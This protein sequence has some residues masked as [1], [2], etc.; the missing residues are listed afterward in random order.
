MTPDV[1]AAEDLYFNSLEA[2]EPR[3]LL[4]SSGLFSIAQTSHT[5]ALAQAAILERFYGEPLDDHDAHQAPVNALLNAPSDPLQDYFDEHLHEHDDEGAHLDDPQKKAEHDAVFDLVAYED[6]THVALRSGL[7]SSPNTWLDLDGD[8]VGDP[9]VHGANV[10]IDHETTVVYDVVSNVELH[11]VRVDG[12]LH[13]RRDMN[14]LMMVDTL[15]V[16][17]EGALEIGAEAFPIAPD[18]LAVITI[19]DNGPIDTQWD[20]MLLSRGLISH[21]R[22]DIHGTLKTAY[23]ALS[24][25]YA[26]GDTQLALTTPAP[27][28]W[29]VGDTLVLTG[30][31]VN[32]KQDEQITILAING[33]R[34][35]V[36]PL[37][38]TTTRCKDSTSTSPTC[39]ATSW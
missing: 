4:S 17:D 30:T 27:S 38:Y 7:W 10:L 23:M 37:K 13:F 18:V 28:T 21:G 22:V 19:T 12:L 36:T 26:K 39:S 14:T 20:P 1:S 35:T 8:Q 3:V 15:V 9:P 33:N 32:G 24:N 29:R 2:L 31:H 11:T 16:D 34:I 5:Q 6:V 25:S